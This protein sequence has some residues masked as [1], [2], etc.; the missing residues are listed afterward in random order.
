MNIRTLILVG[1]LLASNAS[2]LTLNTD[3][4]CLA[5]NI[6][7]E[8]RGE[9]LVGQ[10]FIGYV[11]LNRVNNK[12]WPNNICDVIKQKNQFSWYISD[13][14]KPKNKEAWKESLSLANALL[15]NN[16]KVINNTALYFNNPKISKSKK[17]FKNLRLINVVSNHSFYR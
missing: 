10:I 15:K 3:L 1:L 12:Q 11:T 8:G 14:I 16:V 4:N 2:A 5:A 6:Y 13:N 9:P 17:F 7:Y